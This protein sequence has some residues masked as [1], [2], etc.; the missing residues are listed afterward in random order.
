MRGVRSHQHRLLPERRVP[1]WLSVAT[2]LQCPP[3][4]S[5]ELASGL[6]LSQ[7][8]APGPLF[9]WAVGL[10]EDEV[11]GVP[12]PG[13]LLP[14]M[15]PGEE[16]GWGEVASLAPFPVCPPDLG[17]HRG[18]PGTWQ[19]LSESDQVCPKPAGPCS[20]R[21]RDKVGV[22]GPGVVSFLGL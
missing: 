12:K 21:S 18:H 14:T 13:P 15:S 8:L 5:S 19:V 3:W 10:C 11:G 4:R 2:S 1:S 7:P 6:L 16:R 22:S 9:L 17:P 20:L